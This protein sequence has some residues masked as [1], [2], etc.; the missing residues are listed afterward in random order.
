MKKIIIL[1]LITIVAAPCFSVDYKPEGKEEFC[2]IPYF[3][4]IS[5]HF[6]G[7]SAYIED[8]FLYNDFYEDIDS[9][10]KARHVG[11]GRQ[12]STKSGLWY[13]DYVLTKGYFDHQIFADSNGQAINDNKYEY[14]SVIL[15]N[16][17]SYVYK[18]IKGD[19][20]TPA[21][22]G[23]FVIRPIGEYKPV[24]EKAPFVPGSW[25][26]IVGCDGVGNDLLTY[27]LSNGKSL[28]CSTVESITDV[29]NHIHNDSTRLKLAELVTY[30]EYP[31]MDFDD[32]SSIVWIQCCNLEIA[33]TFDYPLINYIGYIEDGNYLLPRLV[34]LFE[35][36]DIKSI[37][38][39]Y[40]GVE[41]DIFEALNPTF[42]SAGKDGYYYS[43]C[44]IGDYVTT[45]K[46]IIEATDVQIRVKAGDEYKIYSVSD[47]NKEQMKYIF[48]VYDELKNIP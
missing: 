37:I 21:G 46:G 23:S 34:F 15:E 6:A 19:K 36:E 33:K 29:T 25:I 9:A 1:A 40:D 11:Y 20:Y 47:K 7:Y 41:W 45:I 42:E 32:E 12:Y 43:D 8:S 38:I 26:R 3:Y 22:L 10:I 17:A 30:L 39:R 28:Y 18:C 27:E 14:Y 13:W 24:L 31:D 16:G 5:N 48:N 4:D 35:A 44:W 2:F